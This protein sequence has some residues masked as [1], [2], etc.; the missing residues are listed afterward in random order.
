MRFTYKSTYL[1]AFDRLGPHEQ[2]LAIE[3]DLA[4]KDYIITSK[5]P[6]GLR[7]K[8]LRPGIFEARLND[9]L[10]VIWIKEDTEV[11]FALLGNH[12]EVRRF[13]KRF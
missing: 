7:V 4:I 5:A 13:L 6:F 1:K 2:A 11:I 3:T 9:R 12:E 10:R 8:S